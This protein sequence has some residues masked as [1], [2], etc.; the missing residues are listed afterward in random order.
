MPGAAASS[1]RPSC[2]TGGTEEQQ[3][4]P[5]LFNQVFG[6]EGTELAWET[7]VLLQA[8]QSACRARV[9]CK[10]PLVQWKKRVCRVPDAWRGH[11]NCQFLGDLAELIPACEK[12]RLFFPSTLPGKVEMWPHTSP[13][14]RR[15]PSRPPN[16]YPGIEGCST[17]LGIQPAREERKRAAGTRPPEKGQGSK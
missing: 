11:A 12:Q 15:I 3:S 7:S 2:H 5:V 16:P 17:P 4:P 14:G 13:I 6:E 1:N 9:F 8:E 10:R